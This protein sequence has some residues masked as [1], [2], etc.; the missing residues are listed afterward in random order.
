MAAQGGLGLMLG[1]RAAYRLKGVR[2]MPNLS[3]RKPSEEVLLD[4]TDVRS[5]CR[6]QEGSSLRGKRGDDIAGVRAPRA[7]LHKS[8]NGKPVKHSSQAAGRQHHPSGKVEHGE[9]I[10]GSCQPQEY[11]VFA[12][13]QSVRFPQVGV[14]LQHDLSMGVQERLPGPLFIPFKP[15]HVLMRLSQPPRD[16]VAF[17]RELL[18]QRGDCPIDGHD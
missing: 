13:C 16:V 5:C 10:R 2:Q 14:E 3:Q 17:G 7:S 4:P 18:T 6:P 1:V 9:A 12:E 11:V 8:A 15:T